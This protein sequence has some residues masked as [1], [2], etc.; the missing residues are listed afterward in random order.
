MIIVERF[1]AGLLDPAAFVVLD[2]LVVL[3]VIDRGSS[4]IRQRFIVERA[5]LAHGCHPTAPSSRQ[6]GAAPFRTRYGRA[7]PRARLVGVVA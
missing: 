5:H 7:A 6:A 4:R 2:M 3:A 1:R